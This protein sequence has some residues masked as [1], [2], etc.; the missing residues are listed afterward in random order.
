MCLSSRLVRSKV[1]DFVVGQRITR[2][3][4][5]EIS[6][7][8]KTRR[9]STP[10]LRALPYPKLEISR[11]WGLAFVDLKISVAP[12]ECTLLLVAFN[13]NRMNL[14]C[15]ASLIWLRKKRW[16][17]ILLDKTAWRRPSLLRSI[18][19]NPCSLGLG[20]FTGSFPQNIPLRRRGH[21]PRPRPRPPLQRRRWRNWR[22]RNRLCMSG[23]HRR[24]GGSP[25]GMFQELERR[26]A[27]PREKYI[28]YFEEKVVCEDRAKFTPP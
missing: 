14:F 4:G 3:I 9:S 15:P 25:R 5:S 18:I 8:P 11:N 6:P 23:N 19:C 12:T 7:S 16:C 28:E 1:S 24:L 27:E 26:V 17:P 20:N 21:F 2:L 22:N 13:L 10:P